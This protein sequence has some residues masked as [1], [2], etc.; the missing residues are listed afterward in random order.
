MNVKEAASYL[1]LNYMTVYKLAQ[2]H[3]IPACK[4]GGNWR[5]K[6]DIL[7]DWV[8]KKTDALPGTILVVD[9]DPMIQEILRSIIENQ[10]YTVFVAGTGEQALE[11]I[12]RQHYDL[13]F[14]DLKL[15]G[16]SGAELLETIKQKDKES[17]VVIVTAFGDDPIA[18]KAMSLGP[19]LMVRKPFREKDILEVLNMVFKASR[20][21]SKSNDNPL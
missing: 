10:Q 19:L 20:S 1:R 11:L 21:S 6:K 9:D 18:L 13:I 16:I 7:D 12:V 8:Q 3:V 17:M 15:P 14:L 2:K 5:F 4:V